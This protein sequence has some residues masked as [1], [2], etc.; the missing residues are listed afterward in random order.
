REA[1][2][3]RRRTDVRAQPRRPVVVA[4]AIGLGACEAGRVTEMLVLALCL[5]PLRSERVVAPTLVRIGQ[6]GVRRVDPLEG[7]LRVV[8]SRMQV[9]MVAARER[10]IGVTDL[11]GAGVPRYAEDRIVVVAGGRSRHRLRP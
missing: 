5:L 10:A 8:V 7:L 11:R 1:D 4:L 9:G 6:D 2:A 3:L